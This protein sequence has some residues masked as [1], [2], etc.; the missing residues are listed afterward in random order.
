MVSTFRL[1]RSSWISNNNFFKTGQDKVIRFN[2]KSYSSIEFN[3]IF[4]ES[5]LFQYDPIFVSPGIDFNLSSQSPCIDKG[6]DVYLP[7]TGIAPDL[8]AL[9]Y[10]LTKKAPSPPENPRIIKR[11]LY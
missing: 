1:A 11:L 7:F 2:D 3:S 10:G 6:I 5:N 9:E 8:G 4:P